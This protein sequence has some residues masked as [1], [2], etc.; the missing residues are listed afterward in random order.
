[1]R[2]NI[3]FGLPD[4]SA[5]QIERAAR[6]SQ[7]W[8]FIQ[9]L[10]QGLDTEIGDH[11]VRLSGGQRQRIALARA[12]VKDPPILVL[13]EATSMYDLEG[14]SAF[15]EACADALHGRTV[16]LITH[17]PAS[18][19]LAQRILRVENGTVVEVTHAEETTP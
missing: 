5:A 14:E 16:I 17:R 12:L 7:A 13:D 3:A 8:E 1:V 18:L 15:I 19:A 4:A 2:A 6:L 9:H 11:G 10:P